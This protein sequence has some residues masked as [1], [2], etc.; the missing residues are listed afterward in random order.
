[1]TGQRPTV[2]GSVSPRTRDGI[3]RYL[4]QLPPSLGRR[5]KTFDTE[6]EGWDWIQREHAKATLGLLP[7]GDE[8]NAKTVRTYIEVWL[9]KTASK[10]Y[11]PTT[12]DGHRDRLEKWVYGNPLAD[13]PIKDVRA[14]HI[15]SLLGETPINW[16]RVRVS[17]TLSV[18]FEWAENNMLTTGNPH[19]QSTATQLCQPVRNRGK[20]KE[21][22]DNV[23]TPEQF[24]EFI[25]YETDPVYRDYWMFVASTGMRRGEA[26]GMTWANMHI[27]EGWCVIQ[28][29][30]TMALAKFSGRVVNTGTPKNGHK[31][32]A[33]FGPLI[34]RM[35]TAR[36]NEQMTY[37]MSCPTWEPGDRVFDRRRTRPMSANL[38]GEPLN[39]DTITQRFNLFARVLKLPR[40]GGPHGLRRTFNTTA[41]S[42]GADHEL[43][44]LAMGHKLDVTGDYTKGLTPELLELAGRLEQLWFGSR[45]LPPRDDNVVDL[46]NWRR[47]AS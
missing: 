30:I 10:V 26:A 21:H 18:F 22:T 39:P 45:S 40:L 1:M 42:E 6:A 12:L 32:K 34:G 46:A 24:L 4:A 25:E 8:A 16:T 31:R 37:R 41:R 15:E 47:K 29:N 17:E 2:T 5:G 19:R 36:Y 13:L 44:A 20:V 35:L 33:H 43:R 38:P 3:T 11:K 14:M 7:S 23:W 27:D 28:D 9:E